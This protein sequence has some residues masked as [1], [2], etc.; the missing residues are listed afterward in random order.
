MSINSRKGRIRLTFWR[1]EIE[2][3]VS[4]VVGSD[5]ERDQVA[6]FKE[7]GKETGVDC[8]IQQLVDDDVRTIEKFRHR[9]RLLDG[10]TYSEYPVRPLVR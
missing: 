5:G 3:Q 4:V 6:S 7:S 2:D 8:K 9:S 10:W 1:D